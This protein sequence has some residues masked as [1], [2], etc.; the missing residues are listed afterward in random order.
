[1]AQISFVFATRIEQ[2]LYFLYPEFPAFSHASSVLV[3]LGLCWT[4]FLR[5][6]GLFS[7]ER[8]HLSEIMSLLGIPTGIGCLISLKK[9][10]TNYS[11]HFFLSFC[12]V[13]EEDI[14]TFH[15]RRANK[16][17]CDKRAGR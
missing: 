3:Q 6:H 13:G 5:P 4:C 1:M 9:D 17:R 12:R 10:K 14:C 7:H 8:A 15:K 2:I 16:E 11:V